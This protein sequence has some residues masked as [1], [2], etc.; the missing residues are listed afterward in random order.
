MNRSI[1]ILAILLFFSSLAFSSGI[2]EAKEKLYDAY[3]SGD[4]SQWIVVMSELEK[5]YSK[6]E[7]IFTLFEL[8]KSQYGYM[9]LLIDKGEY[10]KAKIILPI[11]EKN[12]STLL[13]YNNDWADA[14]G[15][16]AGIYG[17][18]II[19]FPNQ[20]ILNGPKGKIYLNRATSLKEKLLQ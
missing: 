14:N 1:I 20:V 13:E 9:G 6:T 4:N 10:E 15:L 11:A 18:K 12:I 8:T 17:F 3:I 19:L 16:K 7:N 2:K 5:S